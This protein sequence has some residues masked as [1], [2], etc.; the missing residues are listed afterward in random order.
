MMDFKKNLFD[1]IQIAEKNLLLKQN[2][3][4]S[5][6][7]PNKSHIK[8]QINNVINKI[9]NYK[10]ALDIAVY[11]NE[12]VANFTKEAKEIEKQIEEIII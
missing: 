8:G 9:A 6:E 10:T 1:L 3:M 11:S 4:D 7:K 5:S 2:Q 12:T